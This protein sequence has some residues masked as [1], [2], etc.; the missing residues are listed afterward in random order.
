[1]MKKSILLLTCLVTFSS[2]EDVID[3]ELKNET[4]RLIVDALIR[5]DTAQDFTDANIKVSLSSSFFGEIE[6][7]IIDTIELREITNG[8]IITYEPVPDEP[9]SYRPSNTSGSLVSDNK[10][11]TSFLSNS[12]VE[13]TLNVIY[14]GKTYLATTRFVNSV[15]LDEVVQGDGQLFDEDGIEVQVSFTDIADQE[16]Y[17]IFDFDF[18]EYLP[19]EDRFYQGQQFKFSY[20]YDQQL[21]SGDVIDIKILGADLQFYNYISGILEQSEQGQN[22]PFQTPTATVRGNFISITD[23]DNGDINNNTSL[24]D[25]FILGYFSI[26]QEFSTSLLIN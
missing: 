8:D 18:N 19:T 17:Y 3:V 6:P 25:E 14:N 24:P 26:S 1:M 23:I 20:F 12:N 4:P 16:D 5:V 11:S 7:A 13:F 2:C 21:T 10:I 9:G 15:P 22:G